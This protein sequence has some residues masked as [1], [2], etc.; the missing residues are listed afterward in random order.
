MELKNKVALVTGGA[1]IGSDVAMTLARKGCHLALTYHSSKKAVLDTAARVARYGV[2]VRVYRVNL[3]KDSESKT[4]ISKVQMHF[5]RLDALVNM[6][7]VY[8]KTPFRNLSETSWNHSVDAN[9]KSA[10]LI[11]RHAIS[12]LKRR[13]GRIVHVSDWV[14]ASG[15][16]RYRNFLPYYTAK[17]GL[18]GL[19]ESQA[20]ELAPQVLVNAVA[21]GPILP[22][23]GQSNEETRAVEKVTP[24]RRWGGAGELSKAILFLLETDFVTGECIRVDGGRHL[25]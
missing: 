2:D 16:P 18:I 19:V 20:L 5:G 11:V 3:T 6:T 12:L 4:L 7:S 22:P 24:L 17:K 23:A 9:L 10:F 13:T 14:A 8:A 1:R 15:R 21:P 25:L